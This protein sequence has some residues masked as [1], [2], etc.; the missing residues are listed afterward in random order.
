MKINDYEFAK[1]NNADWDK[2]VAR[3]IRSWSK[4]YIFDSILARRK[5]ETVM[6]TIS[7]RIE[8]FVSVIDVKEIADKYRSDLTEYA[9]KTYKWTWE[10]FGRFTPAGLAL[11]LTSPKKLTERQIKVVE[12]QGAFLVDMTRADI[13]RSKIPK[14][15]LK[16]SAY[17]FATSLDMYEEDVHRLVLQTMKEFEKLEEKPVYYANVN[18]R[19]IAEMSLRF[20]K[21]LDEKKALIQKGVRLVL[22][23]SH[24]NCSKRCQP[25]QGRVY[26]L[27]GTSGNFDGRPFIP[28]EDV[29]DK[30]TYTSKNTGRTYPCGLFSYNC[31][32][33]LVEYK[34][35]MNVEKIPDPVIERQRKAEMKQREMEREYRA[36]RERSTMYYTVYHHS[37]NE[38]VR[39]QAAAIAAQ[40]AKFR[41]NYE[42]FSIQ[43]DLPFIPSRLKIAAGENRYVRTYGKRDEI[44]KMA[45][46]LKKQG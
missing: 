3:D 41:D 29:S 12:K 17:T 20:N 27:D 40:A 37:K 33:K 31:R 44:A 46:K 24:S 43:N 4:L 5:Q 9:E 32:H 26:S 39:R 10:H 1:R 38:E 25:F 34:K 30:V 14:V 22:V 16:D 35:G 7:D 6:K 36:M 45:M 19:N 2:E 8:Q 23:P 42:R 28:I 21:Y 18:P 15:D 13:T 11:A